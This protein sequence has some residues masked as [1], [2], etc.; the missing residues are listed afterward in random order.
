MPK[1][2]SVPTDLLTMNRQ[3]YHS[4]STVNLTHKQILSLQ[5]DV[6]LL[7]HTLN[8]PG[9]QQNANLSSHNIKRQ[10]Y[11]VFCSV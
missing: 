9:L 10:T 11:A 8:F 3:Y 7:P 6:A 5:D 4:P 1:A 2:R